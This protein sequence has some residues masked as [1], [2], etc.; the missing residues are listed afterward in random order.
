MEYKY[1]V[2]KTKLRPTAGR[3]RGRGKATGVRTPTRGKSVPPGESLNAAGNPP[4]LC[5]MPGVVPVEAGEGE[6]ITVTQFEKRKIVEAAIQRQLEL[7]ELIIMENSITLFSYERLKQ[8]AECEVNNVNAEGMGSVNDQRMGI[9]EST[10][11]C[12]T[13]RLDNNQCPGH[14]GY[15]DLNEPIYHPFFLREIIQVLNCLCSSCSRL[16]LTR[17]EIEQ[18]EINKYSLKDRLDLL[19]EASLNATCRVEKQEQAGGNVI[20]CRPSVIYVAQKIKEN[21]EVHYKREKGDT[22]T[23]VLS[24]DR[25]KKI[26]E[27]IEDEDAELLGFTP[28]N[29]SRPINMILQGL[30]VTPPITRYPT[31]MDGVLRTH[32]ITVQYIKIVS[33]NNKLR[34][35]SERDRVDIKK[36]LIKAIQYLFENTKEGSTFAAGKF[37]SFKDLIQGKDAVIR[38]LLMGK[39]GNYIA[40][41][42]LSPRP[43]LK[44]GEIG[45]PKAFAPYLTRQETCYQLNKAALEALME[46]RDVVIMTSFGGEPSKKP[47]IRRERKVTH[48]I[49]GPGHPGKVGQRVELLPGK[50]YSLIYGDKVERHLQNGDMIVAG[51]Q[52]TLHKQNLMAY[53]V[54]LT[55]EMTIGLHLSYTSPLNAD[56]LFSVLLLRS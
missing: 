11:I 21:Y 23:E 38:G 16:K 12:Q 14:L 20:P 29:D 40:R 28:K 36:D 27:A 31:P 47:I 6:G 52:P 44:F 8:I 13:C 56:R 2:Q 54:V 45:V 34:E 49:Y 24:I 4:D 48:I 7:P 18:R 10:Q 5:P 15:I 30:P 3:G 42:V 55:D 22:S 39:T 41:T 53:E 17:D 26:L 37:R 35:V 33:L 50:R 51:R 46:E 43:S 9:I 25:V 19:E 32:P 1:G